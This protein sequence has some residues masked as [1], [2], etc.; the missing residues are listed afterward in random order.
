MNNWLAVSLNRRRSRPDCAWT[1]TSTRAY[2]ISATASSMS[3]NQVLSSQCITILIRTRPSW[4]WKARSEW[5]PIRKTMVSTN[6]LERYC[7]P[8]LSV[9][10]A[11][12]MVWIFPRTC[13]MVWSALNPA[14]SLSAYVVHH[15]MLHMLGSHL[16]WPLTH[17]FVLYWL[18]S[19]LTQHKFLD[20]I[21]KKF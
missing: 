8:A 1:I 12:L 9:R 17:D 6:R 21:H 18:L 4:F 19:F 13:G 3:W 20:L 11:V 5:R 2:R 15:I 14:F 10:R 16:C 7:H